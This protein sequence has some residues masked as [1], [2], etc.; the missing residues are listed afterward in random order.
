[1]VPSGQSSSH[2]PSLLPCMTLQSQRLPPWI[3]QVSPSAQP[4]LL[5]HGLA[6]LMRL[7]LMCALRCACHGVLIC[8]LFPA[9]SPALQ[10]PCQ[11][12]ATHPHSALTCTLQVEGAVASIL[13]ALPPY[14][15]T[16][17]LAAGLDSL[18]SVELR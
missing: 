13:G 18:A 7:K 1:M 2:S 11:A 6:G 5:W 8:A 12:C 9:I 10:P 16:P 17:L 4:V 3:Q 15:D 14:P